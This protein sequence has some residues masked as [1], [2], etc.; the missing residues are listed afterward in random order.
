MRCLMLLLCC[1]MPASAA[2]LR[3]FTTLT[4][5]V[6]TLADLFDGAGDRAL[7]P[8][9]APGARI[10]VEARQLDAIARQFGVDWRSTGA[11]DRVVLDRPG[12]ALG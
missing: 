10:T 3:P 1:A 2:T 8:S 6:V 5:P 4:G 9:P 7:G 12:R 11:G